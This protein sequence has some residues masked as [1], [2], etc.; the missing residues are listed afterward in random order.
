MRRVVL[1]RLARPLLARFLRTHALAFCEAHGFPIDALARSAPRDRTLVHRLFDLVHAPDLAPPLPF[2]AA[3]LLVRL[4]ALATSAGGE[5]LIR[6][7][8]DGVL[9]RALLGD[10]DL[11]LT[12]ILDAPA[13]AEEARVAAESERVRGYT[14]YE[15]PAAPS[16]PFGPAEDEALAQTLGSR[17]EELDRT[18]YCVVHRTSSPAKIALEIVHARRPKTRDKVD[19]QALE[20]WAATDIDTERAFVEIEPRAGRVAIHAA[21][22]VKRLLAESLGVVLASDRGYLRAASVYDLGPLANLAAACSTHGVA[23]L[24]RVEVHDLA[25]RTAGGTVVTF[26]RARRD[27]TA[28]EDGA[29]LLAQALALGTPVAVKLYLT[30]SGRDRALKLEIASKDGR[31]RVDFDRDDPEIVL[32]VREYLRARGFARDAAADAAAQ[33]TA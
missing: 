30:I 29:P 26:A 21:L 5:I 20:A 8:R 33:A 6:L 14:E 15:V 19:A 32:V 9:P 2:E 13:I 16:L 31:N 22:G 27:L 3:R 7:D 18:R 4:D 28:D 1:E 17:L 10:E 23:R 24:Q 25:V 12:A 11:A